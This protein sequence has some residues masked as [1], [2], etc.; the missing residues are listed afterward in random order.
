MKFVIQW[1]SKSYIDIKMKFIEIARIYDLLIG[2]SI[3]RYLFKSD[4]T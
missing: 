2:L 1:K 4:T 3:N